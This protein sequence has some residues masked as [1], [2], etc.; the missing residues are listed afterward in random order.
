[1]NKNEDET[2]PYN[3]LNLYVLIWHSIC[4]CD[5]FTKVNKALRLTQLLLD[6]RTQK[7]GVLSDLPSRVALSGCSMKPAAT[8]WMIFPTKHRKV[9]SESCVCA[10]FSSPRSAGK[11]K[12]HHPRS[13]S[14]TTFLGH[15]FFKPTLEIPKMLQRANENRRSC[16]T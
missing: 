1:M 9:L 3:T 4:N 6:N 15:F 13:G 5:D 12:K 14:G 10:L 11:P 8:K 7:R 2:V 16:R